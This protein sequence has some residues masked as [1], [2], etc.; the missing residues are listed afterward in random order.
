MK[1][2]RKRKEIDKKS[3]V[4][5]YCI[6]LQAIFHESFEIDIVVGQRWLHTS[7]IDMR[8]KMSTFSIE[9]QATFEFVFVNFDFTIYR[10]RCHG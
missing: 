2:L 1:P 10:L 8:M 5:N 9:I 4:N 3:M 7:M 6:V